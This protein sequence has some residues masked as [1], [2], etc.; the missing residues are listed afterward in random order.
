MGKKS[1]EEKLSVFQIT[2]SRCLIV[3]VL[4]ASKRSNVVIVTL[5]NEWDIYVSETMKV[6]QIER[7]RARKLLM[8]KLKGKVFDFFLLLSLSLLLV[9]LSMQGEEFASADSDYHKKAFCAILSICRL[10]FSAE[11][12]RNIHVG[13][14]NVESERHWGTYKGSWR[15]RGKYEWHFRDGERA[16]GSKSL[17]RYMNMFCLV[18]KSMRRRRWKSK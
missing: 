16:K 1:K 9:Y 13:M 8:G 14:L 7:S 3:R 5:S 4:S 10:P 15:Q 11:N 2:T 6:K 18:E 12:Y 17:E